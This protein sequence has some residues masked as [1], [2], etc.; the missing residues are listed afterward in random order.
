MSNPHEWL[1]DSFRQYE[2]DAALKLE[3][4]QAQALYESNMDSEENLAQQH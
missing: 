1:E 2:L 4:E 3:D